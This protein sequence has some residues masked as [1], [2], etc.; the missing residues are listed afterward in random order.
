VRDAIA[1][2]GT[3]ASLAVTITAAHRF[4]TPVFGQFW[5]SAELDFRA[6]A[7][8]QVNIVTT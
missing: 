8:A 6:F 3:R 1:S 5:F 7:R 2:G 4:G